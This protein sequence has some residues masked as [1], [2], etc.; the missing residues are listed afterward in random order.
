MKIKQTREQVSVLLDAFD[1]IDSMMEQRLLPNGK[2]TPTR[3][4]WPIFFEYFIKRNRVILDNYYEAI[5]KKEMEVLKEFNIAR[6]KMNIEHSK[7]DEKD[8]TK[9]IITNGRFEIAD[10]A[11]YDEA[12]KVL[13][14]QFKNELETW[15]TY[16]KEEIE[17]EIYAVSMAKVELLTLPSGV[18]EVIEPLIIA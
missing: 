7:K 18:F 9:P 17:I 13:T 10:Q 6:T 1:V 15:N 8:P 11:K 3:K 12:Y 2:T 5:G 4:A 16:M 14:E